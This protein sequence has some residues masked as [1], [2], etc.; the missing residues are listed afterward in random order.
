MRDGTG[1]LYFKNRDEDCSLVFELN[2]R[3]TFEVIEV[4]ILQKIPRRKTKHEV[5]YH[6]N[7]SDDEKFEFFYY[8]SLL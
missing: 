7:F 1:L 8:D 3:G 6:R 4:S 5:I 2:I